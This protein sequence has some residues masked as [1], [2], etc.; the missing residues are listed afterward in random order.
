MTLAELYNER[1]DADLRN[2][3]EVARD[4]WVRAIPDRADIDAVQKSAITALGFDVMREPAIATSMLMRMVPLAG[5]D[6]SVD[7]TVIAV[8]SEMLDTYAYQRAESESGGV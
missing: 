4:M 8:V 6:L 5:Q 7:A 3:V 2:R 1:I